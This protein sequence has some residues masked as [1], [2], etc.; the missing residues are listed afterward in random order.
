MACPIALRWTRIWWVRPVAIETRISVTPGSC[1]AQVTRVTAWRAR[2]ARVE[3]FSRCTGSRPSGRSMR[4]RLWTTPQTSATYSLSTSRSWNWRAS[5]WWA[6]SCL[7]TTITPDV[8]LSSRC[9]I[10]GRCSPPMPLRSLDVMEQGVDQRARRVAG[11]RVDDQPGGLVDD[12]HVG[13][14]E[15]DVERQILRDEVGRRGLGDLDL[16]GIAGADR[17]I[18]LGLRHPGQPDAALVD[19]AL[20]L[21]P[22]VVGDLAGEELVEAQALVF[23]PDVERVTEGM[24]GGRA[25]RRLG[26]RTSF[27]RRRPTAAGA[28]PRA[29]PARPASAATAATTASPG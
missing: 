17:R 29:S 26:R 22:R 7:A 28:G 13:V 19:Q 2:R 21:R 25:P 9:T 27:V 8:P 18:G 11:A 1:R 24:A 15:E 3:I 10:P 4:R 14:V 16:D 23:R 6:R 20:H 5:S 12:D